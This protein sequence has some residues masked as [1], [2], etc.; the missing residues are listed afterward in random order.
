MALGPERGLF[1]SGRFGQ[2]FFFGPEVLWYGR[3][4]ISD[5]T[6]RQPPNAFNAQPPASIFGIDFQSL[7]SWPDFW[8]AKSRETFP[9][10]LTPTGSFLFFFPPKDPLAATVRICLWFLTRHL[11]FRCFITNLYTCMSFLFLIVFFYLLKNCWPVGTSSV[12]PLARSF[13]ANFQVFDPIA[14]TSCLFYF[15]TDF[16]PLSP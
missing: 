10:R 11:F 12:F 7:V 16:I 3:T 2:P 1:V 9:Q 4:P 8:T 13:R 6:P 15:R 5:L 14:F